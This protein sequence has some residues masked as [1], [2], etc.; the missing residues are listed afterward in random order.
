[1]ISALVDLLAVFFQAGDLAQL[2]VIACS[3]LA[4]IPEDLVALQF[5]GLALYQ[6]GRIEEARAVFV[7]VPEGLDQLDKWEGLTV[8]EPA[9]AATFRAATQAQSGLAEGWDRIAFLLTKF[10]RHKQAVHALDAASA[11]RGLGKPL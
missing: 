8:C 10:G 9:G 11:A 3:M 6:M 4:A 7:R 5:L 1:M 2:E